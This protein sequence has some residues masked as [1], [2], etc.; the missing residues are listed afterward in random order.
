MH[1]PESFLEKEIRKILWDFEIQTDYL[2]P[3]RRS[4]F[5]LIKNNNN[6]NKRDIAFMQF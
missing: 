3:F 4:D 5:T 1:K 2:I 6:D